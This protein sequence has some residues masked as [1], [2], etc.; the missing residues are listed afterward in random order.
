MQ[1]EV[2]RKL[3]RHLTVSENSKKDIV[4]QMGVDPSTLHIVPVGV[5]QERFRPLIVDSVVL[6]LLNGGLLS[7]ADFRPDPEGTGAVLLTEEGQ[8]VFLRW[9]E[10]RLQT[11]VAYGP[12]GEQVTYRRVFEGQARA[13]A[14]VILGQAA[15][16]EPVLV[17]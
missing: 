6:R 14:R 13:L 8:R 15:Q 17:R 11:R 5:D 7:G 4:A 3:P 1:T 12:G 10:E 2:A 16:Y 9:Y